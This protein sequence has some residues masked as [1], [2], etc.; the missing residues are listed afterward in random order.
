[1]SVN[2]RLWAFIILFVAT[3]GLLL[4]DEFAQAQGTLPSS[5]SENKPIGKVVSASGSVSIQHTD[6]VVLQANL[7]SGT[8]ATLRTNDLVYQGEKHR[9]E[10]KA[11]DQIEGMGE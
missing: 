8:N 6:A 5:T 7:G 10:R 2:I 4:G 11:H 1:M 3:I 9:D